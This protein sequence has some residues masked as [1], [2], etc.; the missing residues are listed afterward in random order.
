L[1]SLQC[2]NQTRREVIAIAKLSD[3][4]FK[5]GVFQIACPVCGND[6]EISIADVGGVV[7]CPKCH[8]EIELE[9]T[10]GFKDSV[11]SEID[12]LEKTISKI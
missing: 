2:Y 8:I 3:D 7:V 12:D 4:I 11:S 9:D 6:L 5:S 1:Y 10:E